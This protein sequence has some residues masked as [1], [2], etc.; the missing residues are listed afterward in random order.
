MNKTIIGLAAVALLTASSTASALTG[1]MATKP[2]G[3]NI[4]GAT[5]HATGTV[6]TTTQDTPLKI[7]F[8]PQVLLA[9][10]KLR[11]VAAVIQVQ[12]AKTDT[13][14]EV[15]N[16]IASGADADGY[17][18]GTNVAVYQAGAA[19][20]TVNKG[21]VPD[22]NTFSVNIYHDATLP[23]PGATTLDLP[24]TSYTK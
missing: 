18:A 6:V 17:S 8:T 24:I 23:M 4:E 21:I 9:T 10:S 1:P 2:E 12:N 7:T 3:Y 5:V 20:D 22:S 19:A 11:Q 15:G 16:L 13:W 14:Y